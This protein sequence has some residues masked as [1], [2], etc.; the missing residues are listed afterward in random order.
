MVKKQNNHP[1]RLI[2]ICLLLSLISWF[3]MKMSKNYTQT[4]QFEMTFI[5]IP[6]EK[7]LKYQSD[8]IVSL[9]I[10]AKGLTLFRYELHR[11]NIS[12]EYSTIIPT[13]RQNRNYIT[14][15]KNQLSTYFIQNLGFPESTIINEPSS[16][17][18]EL[19]T[20]KIH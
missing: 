8:T 17:A 1:Y 10:N 7:T 2:F 11:K 3:A 19:E 14:I 20:V 6:A 5:D 13:N 12:I 18:L 15:D 9:T 4:Y 16:I